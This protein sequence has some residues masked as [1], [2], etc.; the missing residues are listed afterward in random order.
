MANLALS[1]IGSRVFIESF[2]ENTPQGRTAKLNYTP[3]MQMLLRAASWDF[4][5]AQVVLT[6]WKQ[7]TINGSPSPN[8]PPQ[9]WLFAYLYP[10]DCIKARF[11]MPTIP[12]ASPGTPLTTAPMNISCVPPVPT[13]IPFVIG[14]DKDPS[15]NPI[16]TL[17][18]NL[19]GAQLVYTRDMSQI[20][21]DWDP[22]YMSGATAL[23]GAYFINALARNKAQYDDQ[24]AMSKSI[25]DQAR[26]A[27]GNEEIASIDHMPDWMA[28]R[29]RSGYNWGWNRAGAPGGYGALGGYDTVTFPDGLRY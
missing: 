5:R 4:A 8:P 17:L 9:P 23:L 3:R 21:D 6:T 26:V 2:D 14:T 29:Q 11:V 24:V 27:N 15:G 13:G 20:P 22:L 16:R 25:I 18:T 19:Q 28:A 7:A 1:E 12:V 10:S